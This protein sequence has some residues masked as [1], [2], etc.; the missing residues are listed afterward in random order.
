[1]LVYLS[2]AGFYL[3]DPVTG[4]TDSHRLGPLWTLLIIFLAAMA[5]KNASAAAAAAMDPVKDM[6]PAAAAVVEVNSSGASG[7][8]SSMDPESQLQMIVAVTESDP[9]SDVP[10][11]DFEPA[12]RDGPLVSAHMLDKDPA[13]KYKLY[14]PPAADLLVPAAEDRPWKAPDCWAQC[15]A[16]CSTRWYHVRA[17]KNANGA[18]SSSKRWMC[19]PC[20]QAHDSMAARCKPASAL[21]E[22]HRADLVKIRNED[23]ARWYELILLTRFPV[24]A[25]E[26][27]VYSKRDRSM[28]LLLAMEKLKTSQRVVAVRTLTFR[29]LDQYIV[30]RVR[31]DGWTLEKATADF[32]AKLVDPAHQK[33]PMEDGLPTIAHQG[34][35]QIRNETEVEVSRTLVTRREI[36]T[37][38]EEADAK[39]DVFGH[40][41]ADPAPELAALFPS[42]NVTGGL[43]GLMVPATQQLPPLPSMLPPVDPVGKRCLTRTESNPRRAFPHPLRDVEDPVSVV[44]PEPVQKKRKL[45]TAV[46][47][48]RATA[49]TLVDTTQRTLLSAKHNPALAYRR[50]RAKLVELAAFGMAEAED[51]VNPDLETFKTLSEWTLGVKSACADWRVDG[52]ERNLKE[53]Q[54]TVE[55]LR[56]LAERI[57][58][59]TAVL[60]RDRPR[61]HGPC[62]VSLSERQTTFAA[63]RASHMT[64]TLPTSCPRHLGSTYTPLIGFVMS[65]GP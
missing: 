29:T 61:R 30:A 48:F 15:R 36:S 63:G 4:S 9:G 59:A 54:D 42:T 19:G 62:C 16:A 35:F 25:D 40:L 17:L 18:N 5:P 57:S 10:P 43:G 28:A 51:P 33:G 7:A 6:D 47:R 23:P 27:G 12:M 45:V 60:E 34:P 65:H 3:K 22:Q 41:S 56:T 55:Q 31:D 26:P 58:S 39:A 52:A 11:P 32:N 20:K 24:F 21:S 2:L 53:L 13:G 1:M 37:D 38:I 46:D 64:W 49:R 44:D 14:V 50:A 8:A